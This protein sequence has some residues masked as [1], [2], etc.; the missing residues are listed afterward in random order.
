M[1]G[2]VTVVY[3]SLVEVVGTID[4]ASFKLLCTVYGDVWRVGVD[5]DDNVM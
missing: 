2:D 3:V 5:D 1:G 4:S